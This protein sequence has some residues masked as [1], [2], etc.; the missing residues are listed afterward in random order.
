M[1]G[2]V[3]VCG[4]FSRK[5]LIFYGWKLSERIVSGG[6][7]D[8]HTAV[9]ICAILVDSQAHTQADTQT[10]FCRLYVISSQLVELKF[11]DSTLPHINQ[12]HFLKS[13]QLSTPRR[14]KSWLRV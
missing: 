7:A 5:R 10:D 3:F 1:S 14:I 9:V 4:E 13:G 2:W 12:C 11:I 6:C 8:R